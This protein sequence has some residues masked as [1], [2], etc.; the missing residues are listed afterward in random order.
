MKY[1][2]F[3]PSK[4]RANM[5]LTPQY[6]EADNLSY[7][8]VVEPQE[9]ELYKSIYGNKVLKL[10]FSNKGIGETRGWIKNYARDNGFKRHW[11][12]DDDLKHFLIWQGKKRRKAGASET[13]E[14]ME[15][16]VDRYINVGAASAFSSVFGHAIKKPFLVNKMVY[17]FML[18]D[19]FIPCNFRGRLGEDVDFTLQVLSMSLCTINFQAFQAVSPGGESRKGGCTEEYQNGGHEAKVRALKARW[20]KIVKTKSRANSIHFDV[21][22]IWKKFTTPLI[23]QEKK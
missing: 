13:L 3:I 23:K 6:L 16:F 19:S 8:I 11:Q 5:M 2:I 21:S 15:S 20:P 14:L 12:L 1:P 22:H 10:P 18:I 7:S 17:G 4:G 9:F